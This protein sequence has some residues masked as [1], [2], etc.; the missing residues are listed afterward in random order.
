MKTETDFPHAS[1]MASS[2]IVS[3]C[4]CERGKDGIQVRCQIK[5]K[6]IS[7]TKGYLY[8]AKFLAQPSFLSDKSCSLNFFTESEEHLSIDCS[9]VKSL[10]EFDFRMPMCTHAGLIQKQRRLPARNH[11]ASWMSSLTKKL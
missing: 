11:T 5:A 8:S 9:F 10:A 7:E 1:G 4:L 2:V 3:V 6:D